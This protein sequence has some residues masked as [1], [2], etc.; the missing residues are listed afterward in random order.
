MLSRLNWV[1]ARILRQLWFRATLV[2]LLGVAAAGLAAVADRFLPD[3]WTLEMGS[4]AVDSILTILASSMLA[5]T[6]FSLTTLT[7]AL[8]DATNNA[9]PR[10]TRLLMQDGVTQ[11]V[12]STFVGAFL[13]SIV[14]LVVL[15]AQAYGASGRAVLFIATIGVLVLVVVSL[16]RWIDHLIKL[17][18]VGETAGRVERAAKT[19]LRAR[20]AAPGM[21]GKLLRP[22]QPRPIGV[23]PVHID[24]IGYVLH[25]DMARIE[26]AAAAKDL[27]VDLSVLPGSFVHPGAPVAWIHCTGIEDELEACIR[28]ACAIGGSRDFDQDPRF[29][30]LVLGEIASRALSPG[31][32]DPGTAIDMITRITQLLAFWGSGRT[33]PEPVRYPHVHVPRLETADLFED[34]LSAIAR[35]GA[36]VIEVQ[37][38]LQKALA[39]LMVMGDEEFREAA[40]Q[41]A[42]RAFAHAGKA[43]RLDEEVGRLRDLLPWIDTR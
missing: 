30:V 3:S 35:D 23:R 16:L 21:G 31:I 7:S 28:A 6:T 29:G 19:A 27:R 12:L 17:G 10:A 42:R 43:L 11:N 18:R 40:R 39:A 24:K 15:Q 14:G 22:G 26:R 13:F 37:I 32:N 9:S 33:E 34:A 1:V 2:G 20:K 41:Q 4:D 36:G 8:G 38:R 25:I 5:V